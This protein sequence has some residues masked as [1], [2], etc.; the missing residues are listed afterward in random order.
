MFKFQMSVATHKIK[1]S[2]DIFFCKSSYFL[3]S[4]EDCS[5]QGRALVKSLGCDLAFGEDSL[6]SAL[7]KNQRAASFRSSSSLEL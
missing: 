2:I 3:Q 5:A 7:A 1:G 6:A 4:W